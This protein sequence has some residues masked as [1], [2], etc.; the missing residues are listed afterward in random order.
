VRRIRTRG[1]AHVADR[2][3]AQATEQLA[4]THEA[5]DRAPF[6][7][8][9]RLTSG[10]RHFFDLSRFSNTHILIFEL[11]TFLMSKFCQIL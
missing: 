5:S 3:G 11:V 4:R 8:R 7:W 6:K 10:P 1:A 9:L 2:G